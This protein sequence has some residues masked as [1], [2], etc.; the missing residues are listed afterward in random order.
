MKKLLIGMFFSLIAPFLLLVPIIGAAAS[1]EGFYDPDSGEDF[2]IETF[3]TSSIVTTVKSWYDEYINECESA[4][5]ARKSEVE[6]EH[7]TIEIIQ[8]PGG[9]QESDLQENDKQESDAKEQTDAGSISIQK[10]KD[11]KF[12]EIA[13]DQPQKPAVKPQPDD[14]LKDEKEDETE[15][16]SEDNQEPVT[17]EREV[18]HVNVI[19][20][21]DDLP[22]SAVLAYYNVLYIQGVMSGEGFKAAS[23]DKVHDMLSAMTEYSEI[24][25]DDSEDY[26]IIMQFKDYHELPSVVIEEWKLTDEENDEY[27]EM[28]LNVTEMVAGWLDEDLNE[29]AEYGEEVQ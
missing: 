25:E 11:S 2:D 22:L 5:N 18:C 13:I 24:E 4:M 9:E 29:E 19:I 23:K 21:M 27:T 7:T 6:K 17:E 1:V 15:S 16:D 28:Y 14:A 10:S 3:K 20:T 8:K 12:E 26:Y